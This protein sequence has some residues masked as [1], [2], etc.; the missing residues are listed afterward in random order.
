MSVETIKFA[1]GKTLQVIDGQYVIGAGGACKQESC[2]KGVVL[3]GE[4][5][6][7]NVNNQTFAC[8]C[9][10]FKEWWIDNIGEWGTYHDPVV[11][12]TV[13]FTTC[14]DFNNP[15]TIYD[16][17]TKNILILEGDFTTI[18]EDICAIDTL[19]FLYI[20]NT[21][22][23]AGVPD[24]LGSMENLEILAFDNISLTAISDNI[25]S[26]QNIKR[27]A[28]GECS[29]LTSVSDKIG[30]MNL[31]LLWLKYNP[32]LSVLPDSIR[33]LDNETISVELLENNFTDDYKDHIRNDL[34][35]I[36]NANGHLQL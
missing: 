18:S 25:Y 1:N 32:N 31:T 29:D 19:Q 6:V 13:T 20:I 15:H 24:S 30:N 16:G 8:D 28:I 4:Y 10:K 7:D 23:L 14:S 26:M 35:P 36:A 11:G 9:E 21:P 12:N 34:F 2:T 5:W 17:S 27:F 33:N 22:N 3:N